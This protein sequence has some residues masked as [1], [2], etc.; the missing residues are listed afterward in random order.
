MV[1]LFLA[2]LANVIGLGVI[3]PLLPYFALHHGAGPL[4]A[5]ALFSL[6]SLAQFL[7]APLWGRLSDKIGRKQIILI[8]FAGSALGYLWLA[9]ATDLQM[10]YLARIFSGAMNGWLATSQAY[11]ADVTDDEGR[12]KGMGMLGAAFGLG[13]I[14]GP[15]LG[16]YLAGE[17]VINYQ[18][19]MLIAAAGS[20]IAL[21]I[22]ALLLR[23]PERQASQGV[24]TMQFL[25]QVFS[26]PILFTLI[27]LYFGMFFVFAG[28]ESTLALWC[29]RILNMGPR[30]VGY[31]MAFAGI[32]GVIVQGGLVGRLVPRMGEPRVI[33]MG[34]LF[35]G[36][37]LIGLPLVTERVWLLLPF[38][39]LFIGFG[40]ANPSLQS[41]ISRTAPD[42]MR[43]GA[44]G[45]AQSASSLG[46]ILGPAWA[47]YAFASIGV[48][49]P[50]FSGSAILI[51][52]VFVTLILTGQINRAK[53]G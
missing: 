20:A 35:I 17:A 19:P 1:V 15:A 46:R 6:F 48:A 29:E 49:W 11:V 43:G 24:P 37:G 16:G 53:Q 36:V 34:L 31:Y 25:P 41:L 22:S 12:A 5:T 32:C 52:I 42:S 28:M 2:A 27:M 13:F 26:T 50:F 40:F 8:S 30:H 38:A 23:E 4:E 21:L 45:I 39:L 10:I 14:L 3:V 51:P 44:M 18:L 9:F 7:T 47:G 33:V